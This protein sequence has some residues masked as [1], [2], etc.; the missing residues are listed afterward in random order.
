MARRATQSFDGYW[1]GI[2]QRQSP[3]SQDPGYV[4]EALNVVFRGGACQGRPGLRPFSGIAFKDTVRGIAFHVDN[5]GQRELLAATDGGFQRCQ[6]QGDPVD[7]PLT[8]LPLNDQA[9]A[10]VQKVHF[11]SLSGG[12]NTTF[13][14]DGVNPNLKWDGTILSRMGLPNGVTPQAPTPGVGVIPKG[15]HDYVITLV[16]P[17]HEGDYSLLAYRLTTSGPTSQTFASPVQNPGAT[18]TYS[19]ADSQASSSIG[20]FDDPQVTKW[21][22]YRSQSPAGGAY[23]YI[24]EATIGAS[25]TDNVTDELLQGGD[26]LEEFVNGAPLAPIVAMVEHRGQLVAVMNTDLSLLRFS[27]YDP[28]YMVPEGWPRSYVQ[29]VSRGDGDVISS[30]R[31]F[32]EWCVVFKNNST[33]GIVGEGF[34]EYKIVP[35]QAGGTRQGI[36]CAFPG[37]VLQV[38]NTVLFASRDGIYRIDREGGLKADRISR[39]IDDL[40]SAANFS[41]GSASFFDRKKRIIG[42]ASHG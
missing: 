24:G 10:E 33:H 36:G 19:S 28:Y 37:S 14:Y 35:V 4:V 21:R 13:I 34:K 1:R 26:P 6:F 25:I 22:L 3:R 9:R 5:T 23:F 42:F 12:N 20:E 11:L 41:L 30:M 18:N 15:T 39:A 32:Y 40:Y 17:Y 7:M 16:S 2:L 31:S 27:H 38:D 29:P 8:G